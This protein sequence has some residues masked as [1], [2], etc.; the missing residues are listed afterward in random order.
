MLAVTPQLLVQTLQ[1]GSEPEVIPKCHRRFRAAY[2]AMERGWNGERGFQANS[3]TEVS[4][5]LDT[6]VSSLQP[7]EFLIITGGERFSEQFVSNPGG[8]REGFL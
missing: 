8:E 1:H 6:M 4:K 2:P 5:A 3:A 7:R